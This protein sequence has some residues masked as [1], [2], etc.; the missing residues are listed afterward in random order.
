MSTVWFSLLCVLSVFCQ[1]SIAGEDSIS[2]KSQLKELVEINSGSSNVDGVS[3]VQHWIEAELKALGF[4]LEIRPDHL[5]IATRTGPESQSRIVTFLVHADTVFEKNSDF[6]HFIE[7]EDGKTAIG[8]GVI[9]EKGGIVVAIE[10]L[11]RFL[12][13]QNPNFSL[14][15][16]SSPSEELGSPGLTDT[17]RVLA[18]DSWLV[19]GFEPAL[20]DGSLIQSRRGDR[21]KK[22]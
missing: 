10:G 20:E 14:R 15:F 21:S 3:K 11:R 22:F 16:V 7:K 13:S 18:K 5:L 1:M 19:L 12:K 6:Q 8:P 9:D 2:L 4:N 17:F